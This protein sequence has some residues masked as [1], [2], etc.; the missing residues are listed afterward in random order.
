MSRALLFF[1]A[2]MFAAADAGAFAVSVTGSANAV[3]KWPTPAPSYYVDAAG[4]PGIGADTLPAVRASVATWNSVSCTGLG[5]TEA[6]TV[7]GVLPS[8]ISSGQQGDGKNVL[9]W[10]TDSRWTLGSLVLAVTTP[11]YNTRTGEIVDADIAFNGYSVQWSL[12]SSNGVADV[13]SVATHELGHLFGLQHVLPVL[14]QPDPNPLPTMAP[15]MDPDLGNRT[16][17]ADDING[18]CYLYPK[19]AYTCAAPTD[20]PYILVGDSSGI[21]S[22][23]GRIA[24]NSG[25]CNGVVGLGAHSGGLGSACTTRDDCLSPLACTAY[26][27]AAYCSHACSANASDAC[28]AGFTCVAPSAVNGGACLPATAVS[29]CSCNTSSACESNCSC[30]PDCK[31]GGCAAAPGHET[32]ADFGVDLLTTAV[33]VIIVGIKSQR[34][35]RDKAGSEARL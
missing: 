35:R 2:L 3:I 18:V 9:T 15:R 14:G 26:S 22:Y 16:L 25:A 33:A 4:A 27:G 31:S 19:T 34:R 1:A 8:L 21:E 7:T 29:G 10:V 6:G 24:C 5:I 32:G 20:C 23:T 28:P 30:D 11:I 17:K 12:T 13:E